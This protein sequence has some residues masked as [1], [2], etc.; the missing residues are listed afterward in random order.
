MTSK[1]LSEYDAFFQNELDKI[2]Y[3][4]T[5]N[6]IYI[7]GWLYWH[8]NHWHIYLDEE[9]ERNKNDI[10]RVFRNPALRDNEFMISEYLKQAEEQKKGLLI[11]GSRRFG[12][13]EFESS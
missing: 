8:L 12:K 5:I 9:D 4:V 13:T 3:G 1:E 11:F 6:G 2:K 7:H 10:L